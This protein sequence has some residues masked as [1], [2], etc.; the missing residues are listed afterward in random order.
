MRCQQRAKRRCPECS[1]DVLEADLAPPADA[2]APPRAPEENLDLDLAPAAVLASLYAI[3][4][5][6]GLSDLGRRVD[7]A[8]IKRP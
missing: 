4:R 1:S 7:L 3:A 8:Y 5:A 2:R 6:A